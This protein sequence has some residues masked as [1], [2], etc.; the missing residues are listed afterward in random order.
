MHCFD[1]VL[2][3]PNIENV[4]AWPIARMGPMKM[5]VTFAEVKLLGSVPQIGS[6]SPVKVSVSHKASL[7]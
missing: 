2:V 4:M 6:A 7:L 5:I 3:C 1:E